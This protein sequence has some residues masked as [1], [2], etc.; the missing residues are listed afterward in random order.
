MSSEIYR[1]F[2]DIFVVV[3]CLT[4]YNDQGV[5]EGQVKLTDFPIM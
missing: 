3:C 5:V 1:K 4:L 2:P